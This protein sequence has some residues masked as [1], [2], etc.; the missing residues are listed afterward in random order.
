MTKKNKV[1]LPEIPLPKAPKRK[2]KKII[3]QTI[4]EYIVDNNI[5]LLKP[6]PSRF[7]DLFGV[8]LDKDK[9]DD[10]PSKSPALEG[11]PAINLYAALLVANDAQV[12]KQQKDSEKLNQ[13]ITVEKESVD[14]N[15]G[16]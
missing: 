1:V 10:M 16:E 8:K 3:F 15:N 9:R 2:R 4:E 6:D 13:N 5:P 11:T 12:L 7:P 14:E